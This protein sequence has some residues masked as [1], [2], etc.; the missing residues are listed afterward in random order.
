[1]VLG[2]LAARIDRMRDALGALPDE[3]AVAESVLGTAPIPA[4]SQPTVISST[5]IIQVDLR[6]QAAQEAERLARA[7]AWLADGEDH[8]ESRP[9]ISRLRAPRRRSGQ[10]RRCSKR[11]CLWAFRAS[12]VSASDRDVWET[13]LAATATLAAMPERSVRTTRAVLQESAALRRLVDDAWAGHIDRLR[14]ARRQPIDLSVRRE[15]D[16]MSVIRED[17]ARM[18]AGLLQGTLFD[19]RRDRAAASQAATLAAALSHCHA[20]LDELR[21]CHQLRAERCDLAFALMLE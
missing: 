2:R 17:H 11:A 21:A 4:P 19:R 14:E 8:A 18:S 3:R 13:I 15:R 6:R 1:L 7:R 9:V 12:A 16:L 5:G 10:A 20:R